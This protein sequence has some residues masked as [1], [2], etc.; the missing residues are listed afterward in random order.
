MGKRLFW[1]ELAGFLFVSAIGVLLHF[2]YEWSGG[3]LFAAVISGVNESTWEHMKLL[4]VPTAVFTVVQI[5]FTG[6]AYPNFLA[7]RTVSLLAGLLLIPVLFYTYSGFLGTYV[8]W[9][10]I[11]IFFLAALGMFVLAAQFFGGKAAEKIEFI[12]IS[13]G[14]K[15]VTR[16]YSRLV[17]DLN[18]GAVSFHS[19]DIQTFLRV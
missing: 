6:K 10:N 4:F 2:L 14:N 8:S 11:S 7:V 18:T 15:Q 3:N 19:H 16:S 12:C 17:K 9:I 5:C 1:W 13:G